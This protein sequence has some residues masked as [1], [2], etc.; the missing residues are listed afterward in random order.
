MDLKMLPVYIIIIL[1][2]IVLPIVLGRKAGISPLEALFGKQAEGLFGKK[3]KKEG[4]ASGGDDAKGASGKAGGKKK[5]EVQKNSSRQELMTAIS[6]SLTYSRRN[7]Y[8]CIVPGTLMH[9]DK[10]ASLAAIVVTKGK[11]LGFNCFGYGGTVTAGFGDDD[12]T[13]VL[14]GDEKKIDSPVVRNRR[15][16]EILDAVLKE[17]GFLNI[18]TEIYGVFTASGTILKDH[19]NTHCCT[20]KAMMEILKGDRFLEDRGLD[21]AK[22]GKALEAHV[23]K[24]A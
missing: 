2:L 5:E 3:K 13:Q 10:V 1:V 20:Q 6:A 12:W 14:N 19:K 15:Q 9:E 18:P 4:T 22:V 24:K 16:K 8:Y 23:K 17:C 11:V 21:P 7:H